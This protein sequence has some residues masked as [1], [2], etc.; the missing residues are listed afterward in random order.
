EITVE[1]RVDAGTTFTLWL[2]QLGTAAPRPAPSAIQPLHTGS[3]PVLVVEDEPALRNLVQIVLAEAG[4]RV[5]VASN[6]KEALAPGTAQG[7]QIDLLVT[8]VVMPG[9]SG[10]QLAGELLRPRPEIQVL[11]MSGY[12]G[13]AL[14]AQGLDEGAT[15]LHK[16]FKP[17]QLL[18]I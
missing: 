14:T 4:Y 5:L 16:P 3:D 9:M 11:Y 15:L 12:F 13:D 7:V 17:E 2:P 1:S 6:A 10:P 18:R 8:D